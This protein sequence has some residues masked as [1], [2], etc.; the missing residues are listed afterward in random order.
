VKFSVGDSAGAFSTPENTL[1]FA[2][3]PAPAVTFDAAQS[4]STLIDDQHLSVLA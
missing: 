4:V 1:T 2:A 3:A